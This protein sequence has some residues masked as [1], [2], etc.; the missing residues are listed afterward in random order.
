[1]PTR[2]HCLQNLCVWLLIS[3]STPEQLPITPPRT[4]QLPPAHHSSISLQVI[5]PGASEKTWRS[6]SPQHLVYP[7]LL[8]LVSG[9]LGSSLATILPSTLAPNYLSSH[10]CDLLLM[11]F[12]SFIKSHPLCW[13]WFF[14]CVNILET[15]HGFKRNC[16]LTLNIQEVSPGLCPSG[17]QIT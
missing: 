14:W 4:N 7:G 6:S 12:S 9:E 1:M 16:Q 10:I 11:R 13:P 17:I 8:T 5:S 2:L 3:S 15:L